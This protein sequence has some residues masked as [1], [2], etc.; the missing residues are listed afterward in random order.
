LEDLVRVRI[1][2][3]RGILGTQHHYQ[4]AH[5]LWVARESG[6]SKVIA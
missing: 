4:A 1:R 3:H 6:V 2:P 5:K